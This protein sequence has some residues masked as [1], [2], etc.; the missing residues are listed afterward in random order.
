[1]AI[2]MPQQGINLQQG[3]LEWK[4]DVAVASAEDG[5]KLDTAGSLTS[6]GLVMKMPQEG[7]SLNQGKLGWEG[8]VAYVAGEAGDLQVDGKLSLEKIIM[9]TADED[10][11]LASLDELNIDNIKVQGLDAITVNNLN[12]AGV[13]FAQDIENNGNSGTA[14]SEWAT[15]QAAS[16]N[17][18]HIQVSDGNRVSIATIEA[19]NAQYAARRNS[20]GQWRLVS[21]IEA[22]PFTDRDEKTETPGQESAA[23]E[24]P[25]SMRIGTLR[26]TGDSTLKL[27]DN[28]VSPPFR[29]QFDF[30]EETRDIDTA[31]PDQDSHILLTGNISKHNRIEITGTIQPFASPI[32]LN[33]KGTVEG[34][35]LPPL[36]PYAIATIGYRFD[37]GQLDADS[38]LRIS[39]GQLDGKNRLTMR[40]LKIIPVDGEQR[41]KMDSQLA[42]SLDRGLDMLRDDNNVIKLDLPLRGDLD[43]PDF[44]ISDVI[45]QAVAK[46]TKEAALTYLTMALQPYGS[47]ITVA[48][49]AAD[50]ASRVRLDPVLFEPAS[51]AISYQRFEYLDKVAGVIKDRPEINIK[52]CGVAVLADREALQQQ[53]AAES[54]GKDKKNESG[55]GDQPVISDEQ[56][57]ELADQRDAAVKDY[58]V[59][60]HA[61]KARRLVACQPH[62]DRDEAAEARVDLLI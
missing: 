14:G 26:V 30:T 31:K 50:V 29:M 3:K 58:L 1:L 36:S 2:T 49:Y 55:Q 33:L 9:G 21:I 6:D 12:V 62:I 48:R 34:L 25:G 4:G 41:D 27:E 52:L 20:E 46:A 60:R 17:L 57:I 32:N 15:L 38:T 11:Q 51:Y 18:N 10:I 39:Q 54:T 47:L 24:K 7:F 8:T 61:I 19:K 37:S 5:I 22:L 28:T 23:E 35:E 44:D 53:A 42:V 45:N 16:I 40:S 59:S 56:L 13:M 43:H